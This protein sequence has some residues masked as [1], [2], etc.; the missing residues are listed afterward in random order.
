M[1]GSVQNHDASQ[2]GEV[3][4]GMV[5]GAALNDSGDLL[6]EMAIALVVSDGVEEGEAFRLLGPANVA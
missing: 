3:A 1:C 4:V 5:A 2:A 6:G